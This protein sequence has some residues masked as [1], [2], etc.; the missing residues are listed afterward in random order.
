MI[1]YY[2]VTNS[3]VC[4]LDSGLSMNRDEVNGHVIFASDD[5][6]FGVAS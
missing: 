6:D 2:L 3:P 4:V 5:M 1:N